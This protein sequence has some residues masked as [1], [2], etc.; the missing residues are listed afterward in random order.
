[1]ANTNPNS[2]FNVVSNQAKNSA[3]NLQ[4][5]IVVEDTSA[6]TLTNNASGVIQ[7]DILAIDTTPLVYAA[8][9]ATE[10]TFPVAISGTNAG[11]R[12]SN[13]E[14][15]GLINGNFYLG[16]GTHVLDNAEGGII[17]GGINVDQRPAIATFSVA[18]V[19]ST[20]ASINGTPLNG[21]PAAGQLYLSAGGTDFAGNTCTAAGASTTN[22]GCAKTTTVLATYV[23]GQSF[24]FTNEG[25]LAGNIV[26]N[27]Q[28]SSVNSV[29][30]TGAGFLGSVTA[31]NG[32]GS[33][34]L[35][36]NNVPRLTSVSNFSNVQFQ[37]FRRHRPRRRGHAVWRHPEHDN[38]WNRRHQR[39]A[40]VQRWL[41]H[42]HADLYGSGNHHSGAGRAGSK[43]CG[44]SDRVQCGGR[45]QGRRQLRQHPWSASPPAKPRRARF[46]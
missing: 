7:G 22:A 18:D 31:V 45:V 6:T 24:T 37:A 44:L 13:I 10:T 1:M 14:N 20:N 43:W 19:F 15:E 39:L 33:N 9:V 2:P 40:L 4:G 3:G 11:P 34:T 36:L 42:R 30:L 32:T 35:I 5:T 28:P 25:S 17:A 8:A 26:I 29:T 21:E 12:D 46:S 38:L 27:D 23:G 16:S 41:D